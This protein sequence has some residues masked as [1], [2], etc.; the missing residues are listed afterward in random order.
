MHRA[1]MALREDIPIQQAHEETANIIHKKLEQQ[2][3]CLLKLLAIHDQ[4]IL[5]TLPAFDSKSF[6]GYIKRFDK[7]K[8]SVLSPLLVL[9]SFIVVL[10][11]DGELSSCAFMFSNTNTYMYHL[12]YAAFGPFTFNYSDCLCHLNHFG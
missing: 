5:C 6:C 10:G 9:V 1:E 4:E 7:M 2:K 12:P 3:V 8:K 11:D